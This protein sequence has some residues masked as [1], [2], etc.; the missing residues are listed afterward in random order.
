MPWKPEDAHRHKKGL[1][2]KQARQ[3]AHVANSALATC[4]ADKR[5]KD[6]CEASAVRQA[7]SAVGAPKEKTSVISANITGNLIHG[8]GGLLAQGGGKSCICPECKYK[9]I[10]V[11]CGKCPKCG[12]QMKEADVDKSTVAYKALDGKYQVYKSGDQW[13]WLAVSSMAVRDKEAEVVTE[14]A[15]DDAIAYAQKNGSYGE[16]DL[17]H[18]DGT[19]IGDCDLM[20]RLGNRLIEGGVWRETALAKRVLKKVQ[21]RPDEDGISLKFRFDPEQFD[22]VSY[23]GGIQIMKRAILPRSMAA[24]YG[25]AIAAIEGGSDAMA[26]QIDDATKAALLGYDVTE[27]ELAELVEKQKSLPPEEPNVVTK[28]EEVQEDRPAT[29]NAVLKFFEEIVNKVRGK[30]PEPEVTEP[31]V[32]EPPVAEAEVSEKVETEEVKT[33]EQI[34]EQLA[35]GVGKAMEPLLEQVKALN[36]WRVETDKRLQ[37]REKAVEEKAAELLAQQPPIVKARVSELNQTVVPGDVN[38]NV[39]EKIEAA[40]KSLMNTVTG[41]VNKGMGGN[42]QFKL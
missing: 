15:Y 4:L 37:A 24:S 14:K 26:K 38:K 34:V 7:N 19:E 12:A 27:E 22:G 29:E 6:K 42:E 3:W 13:R 28:E 10:S 5:P 16:L 17:V 31:T 41:L 30:A 23:L 33:A 20:V 36:E 40:Q 35:V 9:S 1:S 11:S 39:A 21:T 2:D 32:T 18:V 25:T 8:R